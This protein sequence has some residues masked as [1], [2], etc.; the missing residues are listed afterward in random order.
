[1]KKIEEDFEIFCGRIICN[2]L[3]K[4][5][6]E[7]FQM[8]DANRNGNLYN[9]LPGMLNYLL[10]MKDNKAFLDMVNIVSNVP[11]FKEL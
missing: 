7:Y 8:V 10:S 5:V 6:R 3:N 9:T 11:F 2:D 4:T 1:M